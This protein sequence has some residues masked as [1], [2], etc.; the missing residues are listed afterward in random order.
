[1]FSTSA[2]ALDSHILPYCGTFPWVKASAQRREENT[3]PQNTESQ[4]QSFNPEEAPDM[5]EVTGT[6]VIELLQSESSRKCG[7]RKLVLIL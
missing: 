7:K 4:R 5:F 6:R 1:M 2:D 3:L